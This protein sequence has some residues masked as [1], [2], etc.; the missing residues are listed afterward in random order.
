MSKSLVQMTA[1][2]IQ[3]Q[4]SSKQMSTEEIKSALNE[5]FQALKRLQDTESIE[6]TD[7]DAEASVSSLID[8]KKSIQRNKVVCLECGQEFKT[9]SPKHLR[10]H[11]LTGK[12]YRKK[13]G[14]SAKQP[15]C[16]KALSE[17]RS[18]AGK[19]RGIPDNLKKAIVART[20]KQNPAKSK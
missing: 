9:L 4:I 18:I 14:F 5:T 19:E 17:K 20:K 2:I 13:Y 6:G 10:A 3:S 16:A 8:P 15:L 1:E 11:G 7:P 12:E